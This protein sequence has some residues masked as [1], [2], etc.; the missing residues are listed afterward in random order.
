MSVCKAR[1]SLLLYNSTDRSTKKS[2]FLCCV[3]V[4]STERPF[5]SSFKLGVFLRSLKLLRVRE[6]VE[7]PHFLQLRSADNG[8]WPG[9]S[10]VN[11]SPS[12]SAKRIPHGESL[13]I[14]RRR[15]LLVAMGKWID[16]R[17][18]TYGRYM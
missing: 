12:N 3:N 2:S 8:L 13:G 1:R 14:P 4:G 18:K 11:P 5:G 10:C 17:K 9:E 15:R 6:K 16:I 7:T